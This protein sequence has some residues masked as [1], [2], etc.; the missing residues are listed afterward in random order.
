MADYITIT[1]YV[2]ILTV[3]ALV[4]FVIRLQELFPLLGRHGVKE[5]IQLSPTASTRPP[6]C[7][8]TTP[9]TRPEE[10]ELVINMTPNCYFIVV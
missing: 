3:R 6:K 2:E 7:C 8:E 1:S 10:E 4:P 5:H 9:E